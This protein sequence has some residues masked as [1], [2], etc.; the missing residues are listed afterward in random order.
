MLGGACGHTSDPSWALKVSMYDPIACAP[1]PPMPPLSPPRSPPATWCELNASPFETN[2]QIVNALS[3][4]FGTFL[5]VYALWPTEKKG[6]GCFLYSLC[7]VWL[8]IL[9]LCSALHHGLP[10]L[11][12]T[13]A[14]DWVATLLLCCFHLSYST[15][16]VLQISAMV[17]HPRWLQRWLAFLQDM[18]LLLS[19]TLTTVVLVVYESTVAYRDAFFAI[20][21]ATVFCHVLI[22]ALLLVDKRRQSEVTF[23]D[24]DPWLV[25]G[26][27]GAI[28]VS[29]ALALAAQGVEGQSSGCPLWLRGS[30]GIHFIWHLGVF[31]SAFLCFATLRYLTTP[32]AEVQCISS[33]L[34]WLL[35]R[36]ACK[37][38]AEQEVRVQP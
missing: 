29:M 31:Y 3:S 21:G 7:G 32:C 9:G 4:L 12:W 17:L 2:G 20:V 24:K 14:A 23:R 15:W 1:A 26:S 10:K 5:G 11:K 16:S 13:Y 25:L 27:Y 18:T 22:L 35:F 36:V 8:I 33:R 30:I 37:P 34:P 38:Q 6:D 19:M 28:M